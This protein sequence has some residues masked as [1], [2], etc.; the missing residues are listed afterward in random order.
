M[1]AFV[2][3]SCFVALAI[4]RP[5]AG[6][7]Y[8]APPVQAPAPSYSQPALSSYQAGGSSYS[9]SSVVGASYSV[10]AAEPSYSSGG[11]SASYS[12]G[13][14]SASYSSG[15]AFDSG[16]HY[17]DTGA[18]Y[19]SGASYDTGS[20]GGFVSGGSGFGGG[21]GPSTTVVQK[22]IYVHVP[23]PEPEQ[24]HQHQ[25]G[26][27]GVVNQKHYKI[28]FIKAPS[29][30][31]YSAAQ[32]AAQQSV[33]QEKTIVYVL[34]KKPEDI[35]AGGNSLAIP[36]PPPSKPEVYFIKYKTQG[37]ASSGGQISGGSA[38]VGGAHDAVS[39]ISYDHSSAHAQGQPSL[40][41]GPPH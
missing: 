12:S 26:G 16:S 36:Q 40:A 33:S 35:E 28:I 34:V 9:D 38:S 25:Q 41:Y 7:S 3:V 23:P 31:S 6:Y 13:G 17:A 14:S 4:A 29:A 8:N 20:S 37:G 18:N 5:E 1:R 19:N 39:G 2:F 24:S 27:G 10:G 11:A 30:P 22:H 32:I 21:V 15:G